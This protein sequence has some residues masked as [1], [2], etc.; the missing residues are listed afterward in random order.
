MATARAGGI[1]NFRVFVT[2]NG[3]EIIPGRPGGPVASSIAA[4][5]T[6]D[7]D[8]FQVDFTLHS[9]IAVNE[10]GTVFV[11]SGGTPA[12]IG[13]NPSPMF[14]EILCFEDMCPM[15]RRADFTDLRGTQVPNP[16][17]SGG[18]VGDGLDTR[19]DHIFHQ[20]P[21]DQVTLTPTGLSGLARGF[22]RYTNRLAPIPIG[23]GVLLGFSGV[24]GRD[25]TG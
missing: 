14:T 2:G 8:G 11:I 10:E 17:A 24:G 4:V 3:P 12:G 21:I 6:L 22:L 15:D 7:V 5:G 9:G 18:N 16:P 13:K 25:R 19:F 23:P 1:N 20:A